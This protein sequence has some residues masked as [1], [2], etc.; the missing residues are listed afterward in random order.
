MLRPWQVRVLGVLVSRPLLVFYAVGLVSW[1]WFAGQAARI[2]V[3]QREIA[4][5]TADAERLD[6]LTAQLDELR[7]RYEQVQRMLSAASASR[8]TRPDSTTRPKPDTSREAR[9]PSGRG[10]Q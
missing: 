3:L 9:T 6:A 8:A 7:S 10:P 4:V 5:L 1:F 2:P